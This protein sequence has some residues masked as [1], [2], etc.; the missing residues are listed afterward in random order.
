MNLID[1][2]LGKPQNAASPIQLKVQLVSSATLTLEQWRKDQRLVAA[3]KELTR[4]ETFRMAM[5]VLENSHP[6]LLAFPSINTTTEDRAAMQAKIEGYQLC[7][8]N[9][10]SMSRDY[11]LSKP[12]VAT[13]KPPTK[14]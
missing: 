11:S 6:R 7:L 8:N 2:I 14:E 4:N 9:L 10:E 5:A 1:R 12:L 13:F 3:A